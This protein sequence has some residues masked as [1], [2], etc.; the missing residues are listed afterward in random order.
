MNRLHPTRWRVLGLVAA[1]MVLPLLAG[2]AAPPATAA[3]ASSSTG[4]V[5]KLVS[6]LGFNGRARL[7]AYGMGYDPT[8]GTLLVGDLWNT[9]VERWTTDGQLIGTV[10]QNGPAGGHSGI[11]QPFGVAA[12]ASGN[13]WVADPSR[14]RIVEFDHNGN[15]LFTRYTV[16]EHCSGATVPTNLAFDNDPSSPYYQYLFVSDPRCGRVY[17]FDHNGFFKWNFQFNLTG[18]GITVPIPRGL[19]VDSNPASPTHGEV[20]VSEMNSRRIFVFNETGT[21][22]SVMPTT[23]N[24]TDLADPRGMA[25][26]Q[27]RGIIYQVG[28]ANNV[29]VL[30]KTDGTYIASWGVN[31]STGRDFNTIRYVTVDPSGNVYVSDLYG[32][33][34]WKMDPN[35][36]LL[37]WGPNPPG[38]PPKGGLGPPNGGY[39][40]NLGIAVD[41]ANKTLYVVDSFENR[42]QEFNVLSS[43]PA[44]GNCPAWVG[45]F[46]HR[47]PLMPDSADLDYPHVIAYGGGYLFMDATNGVLQLKPDGTLVTKWA[48][49][50]GTAPG[51][52]M[53]GPEGI[54]VS[55]SSVYTTDY[56]TCYLAQWTY[57]GTLT[58]NWSS[59]GSGSDQMLGPH[60]VA[61][62]GN[63]AF[64]AD[65]HHN[66]IA[67]WDLTSG[68]IAWSI[69]GFNQP[70]GVSVDPTGTWV[71]VAD[72][73]NKRIVRTHTDGSTPEVVTTTA[74]TKSLGGPTYLAFDPSGRLYVSDATHAVYV[75]T[76]TG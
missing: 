41:P 73:N 44:R 12:D 16:F 25:L 66:R 63:F 31:T 15:Y 19:A 33:W 21:Q 38:P 27:S 42:V 22:L 58:N 53:L 54:T 45:Q 76:I 48:A 75:Y 37:P 4:P 56:G 52:F 20:F 13:V 43:C 60:Q 17:V 34:V 40:L 49:T 8:D 32:Y 55:G 24:G 2:L 23:P 71:Y 67:V 28:A 46:G 47:G 69:T 72:T 51:Q 11:S 29:V 50:K 65:T 6:T 39:N 9:K 61:I 57:T 3:R 18:I 36:N 1:L 26:D 7:Y 10:S 59:C 35:G 74:G 5:V 68:H 64:V 14:A 70:W 30:Y 62:S